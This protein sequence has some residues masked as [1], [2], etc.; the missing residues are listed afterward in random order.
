MAFSPDGKWLASPSGDRILLWSIPDLSADQLYT[1]DYVERIAF[2]PNVDRLTLAAGGAKENVRLWDV[3]SKRELLSL[4]VGSEGET[5][6]Y[7]LV[8]SPEGSRLASGW[9]ARKSSFGIWI[10]LRCR[11]Y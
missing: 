7:S 2:R 3:A 5:Q 9:F 8:F 10:A 6:L 11:G 1:G 4:P